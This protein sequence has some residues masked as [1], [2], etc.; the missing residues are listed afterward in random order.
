M[1]SQ[2]MGI[3]RSI[4]QMYYFYIMNNYNIKRRIR[5]I[6]HISFSY[7]CLVEAMWAIS[8]LSYSQT[9]L[10][11]KEKRTIDPSWPFFVTFYEYIVL[12]RHLETPFFCVEL[13]RQWGWT[14]EKGELNFTPLASTLSLVCVWKAGEGLS[15]SCSASHKGLLSPARLMDSLI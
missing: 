5:K 1:N 14:E 11:R 10:G 12:F 8:I 2:N 3:C 15:L 9:L 13:E 7:T 6:I 4:L